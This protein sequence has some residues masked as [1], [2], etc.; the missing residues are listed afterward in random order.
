[1]FS[2][3]I[4]LKFN[5]IEKVLLDLLWGCF[6]CLCP[7]YNFILQNEAAQFNGLMLG[8]HILAVLTYAEVVS[9]GFWFRIM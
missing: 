9:N 6:A 7:C 4:S 2:C 5:V 1:M 3:R 8:K